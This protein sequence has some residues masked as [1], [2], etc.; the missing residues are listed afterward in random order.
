V[1]REEIAGLSE[2]PQRHTM[3]ALCDFPARV[4]ASI[5]LICSLGAGIVAG[6]LYY[7]RLVGALIGVWLR[8]LGA[9]LVGTGVRNCRSL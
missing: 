9:A 4:S 1:R 2:R 3:P 5:A 8:S 6:L 7:G